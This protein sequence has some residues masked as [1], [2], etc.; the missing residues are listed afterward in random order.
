M[1]DSR[2]IECRGEIHDDYQ[3]R[4]REQHANMIWEHPS[5]RHSFYRNAEGK[6]T[7]LWP[8]KILDMWRWTKSANP[9]DYHFSP[10]E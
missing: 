8:W 10:P 7:L 6:V 3:R 5:I 9:A 4:F 2:A 1:S